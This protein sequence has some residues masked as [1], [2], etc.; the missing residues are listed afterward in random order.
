[1]AI[2]PLEEAVLQRGLQQLVD[3]ELVFQRG[4]LPQARYTFKHALIQDTAYESLLK[5][6]RRQ[7]HQQVAQVLE[8]QF[9][10]TVETQPEV[11][12]QHYTEAGLA[13]QAIG[14]W[15]QQKTCDRT[16]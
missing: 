5:S 13:E 16:A 7:L 15:Q 3:A 8:E 10:E 6:R 2:S 4:L 11:V 1:M 12:A 9:P 14:Y